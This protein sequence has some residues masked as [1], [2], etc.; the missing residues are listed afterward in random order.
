ML[1]V[2]RDYHELMARFEWAIPARF[3]IGAAVSDAWAA[4]EPDRV[5]LQRFSPMAIT[6]S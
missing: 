1:P 2:I 6:S 4:R 3:N 5:C